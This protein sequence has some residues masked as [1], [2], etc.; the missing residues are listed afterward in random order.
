MKFWLESLKGK[1]GN[2]YAICKDNIK[3]DLKGTT[4]KWFRERYG[5]SGHTKKRRGIC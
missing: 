1:T 3:T 5:N 4:V 2:N